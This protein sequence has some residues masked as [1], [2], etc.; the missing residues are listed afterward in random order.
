ME[1]TSGCDTV[2]GTRQETLHLHQRD[3]WTKAGILIYTSLKRALELKLTSS[4]TLQRVTMNQARH[5]KFSLMTSWAFT[6]QEKMKLKRPLLKR[7][8]LKLNV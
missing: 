8:L 3:K 2:K 4:V 7:S 6:M 5:C 1:E